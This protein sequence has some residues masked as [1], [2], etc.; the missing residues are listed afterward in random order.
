MY[1]DLED[2]ER[3]LL[4]EGYARTSV[5]KVKADVSVM[6]AHGAHPP[7]TQQLEQRLQS[8]RHSWRCYEDYCVEM[9]QDNVLPEPPPPPRSARGRKRKTR[10]RLRLAESIPDNEWRALLAQ[11]EADSSVEGRVLDVICSTALRIGDVLRVRRDD[12]DRGLKRDDGITRIEV[13]GAKELVISV[14]GGAELE[15]RR[16]RAKLR[17][18]QMVCAA[19]S[20][21]A[22]DPEDWTGAGAAYR[23]VSRRLKALGEAAGVSERLHPHRIRRTVAVRALQAGVP[24]D[25]VQRLL[26]HESGRTTDLYLDES[27]AGHVAQIVGKLRGR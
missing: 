21:G 3:W 17:P 4:E 2:F 10:K 7:N 1:L 22:S 26:G 9:N 25:L 27:M 14:R 24:K 16:L 15:W 6:A 23:R 5:T 20:P 18:G 19:V 11:V 12:I 13:K 8:L